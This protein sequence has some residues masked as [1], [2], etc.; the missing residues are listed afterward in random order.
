MVIWLTARLR[1][2]PPLILVLIS[3]S[4]RVTQ[5]RLGNQV[6]NSKDFFFLVGKFVFYVYPNTF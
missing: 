6:G 1:F 2:C 5:R 3:E 4:L